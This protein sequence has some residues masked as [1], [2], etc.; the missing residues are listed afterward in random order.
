LNPINILLVDDNED[1]ILLVHEA[2]A[3][4]KLL[5]MVYVARDGE[6]AMRYLR[7]EG[8]H[9]GQPAPGLVLLDIGM[10]RMNGFEVLE[11]IKKTERL[12][13]VPVVMLTTSESETDIIKSYA[14]GACSYITKPVDFDKLRAIAQHFEMYWTLVSAV[15]QQS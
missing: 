13:H 9:A 3:D 15:P 12:R 11:E 1:D 7:Q 5:N 14:H 2:F 4:A 6:Q 8:E 10:P